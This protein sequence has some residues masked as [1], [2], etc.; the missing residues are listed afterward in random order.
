MTG[1]NM[2]I[3]KIIKRKGYGLIEL[4][5]IVLVPSRKELY[6]LMKEKGWSRLTNYMVRLVKRTTIERELG[7]LGAR[8]HQIESEME[9]ISNFL[10]KNKGVLDNKSKI[11]KKY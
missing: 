6:R 5:D 8:K 4:K 7:S 10:D 11:K 1:D 9:I 3:Y 2:P